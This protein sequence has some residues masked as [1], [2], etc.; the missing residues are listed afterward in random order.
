VHQLKKRRAALSGV[1]ETL[2]HE[3]AVDSFYYGVFAAALATD[4][5]DVG[6]RMRRNRS[7]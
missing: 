3:T 4:A 2:L 6:S 5:N 1:A 7:M